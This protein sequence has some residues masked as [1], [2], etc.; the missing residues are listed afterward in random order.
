MA[1]A[2]AG[3]GVGLVASVS[4]D[5]HT[6]RAVMVDLRPV[7]DGGRK[8]A[9]TWSLRAHG[10]G[11]RHG[12]VGSTT[13]S[14]RRGVACSATFDSWRTS[15]GSQA[16]TEFAEMRAQESTRPDRLFNDPYAAALV[17]DQ[18]VVLPNSVDEAQWAY[19]AVATRFIDDQLQSLVCHAD[20]ILRQVVII[21]PGFD[22][23]PYRLPWPQGTVIFE[24]APQDA[25][26]LARQLLKDAGVRMPKGRVLRTVILDTQRSDDSWQDS[27]LTAGYSGTRS[28]VWVLQGI[29]AF[30]NEGLQSVL[31][32]A[33]DLMAS[34]STLIGELPSVLLMPEMEDYLSSMWSDT[35]TPSEMLAE[36]GF[37]ADVRELSAVA[38]ELGRELPDDAQCSRCLFVA[39]QQRLSEAERE[40]A[41]QEFERA[42]EQPDED[43]FSDFV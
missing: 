34:S 10:R 26:I 19:D 22:T 18:D 11:C 13:S 38:N 15:F 43:S 4:G 37:R 12:M 41:W 35:S 20:S 8:A 23:R 5:Q 6:R 32:A 42:E 25:A 29:R 39:T 31:S 3:W 2:A 7:S 1:A 21:G 30:S 14:R 28:S 16:A 36:N 24:I 17:G 27:L 33:S 40:V 9:L